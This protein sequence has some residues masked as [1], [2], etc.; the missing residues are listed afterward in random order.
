MYL[1]W[2]TWLIG[3]ACFFLLASIGY[4]HF[5]AKDSDGYIGSEACQE[6]HQSNYN[7]WKQTLHSKMF[8]P[9]KSPADILGDFATPNPLVTF[10]KEEVKFVVG[11]KWEQVYAR[12]LDGE[13]YPL[14]AKWMIT[15]QKWVSMNLTSEKDTPMSKTCNG[16]H[17]TGFQPETFEFKEF[18][19]GCEACHGSGKRHT[20]NRKKTNSPQ[21][22]VC[23]KNAVDTQDII[24]SVDSTVCGQCHSRGHSTTAQQQPVNFQ[25]PL[26]YKPGTA[27]PKNFIPLSLANDK[28]GKFWWGNGVAKNRH[29][30][31]ADW[32]NSG[33]SKSLINLLTKKDH[34]R[35]ERQDK[36]LVCHSA[37]YRAAKDKANRPTLE[38]A[39][40]GITCVVC[41]NP[42]GKKS[43]HN[44]EPEGTATCAGCHIDSMAKSLKKTGKG[45][46]PCPPG[47]PT[48]VGCH[49]P[50]IVKTGGTFTLH[51]HAFAIVTPKKAKELGSPSSCQNAGCH[52][53]RSEDWA[54]QSYKDFYGDKL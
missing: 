52:L 20:I 2:L 21:C 16:C 10:S 4:T 29:Q 14:P 23:H 31:Y 26:N 54:I 43:N 9:V 46:Y 49:M 36:C 34:A 17:T 38:T 8:R 28:K 33:H 7:S 30:E 5:D 1:K 27:L 47:A 37:D 19:I 22:T 40:Q 13:Y 32:Q 44:M 41:H 11:N 45:H 53:D 42:H 48:C 12:K 51:S 24:R 35:G 39:Q 18:G 15:T 6:C 50:V 25:F 3:T